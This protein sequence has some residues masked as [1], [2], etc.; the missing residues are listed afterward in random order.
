MD[1]LRDAILMFLVGSVVML[2]IQIVYLA[3]Q[4]QEHKA[5]FAV[6][7]LR[8]EEIEAYIGLKRK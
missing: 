1:D 2:A 3:K 8:F 4:G 7:R 6:Q 5:R